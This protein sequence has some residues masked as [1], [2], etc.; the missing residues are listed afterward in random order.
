MTATSN[1]KTLADLDRLLDR[2]AD[3]H[4]GFT[5]KAKRRAQEWNRQGIELELRDPGSWREP[6]AMDPDA[7]AASIE[8]QLRAEI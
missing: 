1:V 4:D 7:R 3:D 5:A 6:L 8:E 2:Y